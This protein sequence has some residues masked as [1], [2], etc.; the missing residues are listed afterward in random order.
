SNAN[1]ATASG[2]TRPTFKTNIIGS[3]PVLRFDGSDDGLIIG[4]TLSYGINP[5]FTVMALLKPSASGGVYCGNNTGAYMYLPNTTINYNDTVSP[6]ASDALTGALTDFK[7]VTVRRNV[8]NVIYRENKTA[9]GTHNIG[10]TG[11]SINRVGR[12]SGGAL[13]NGDYIE[14]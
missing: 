5:T 12:F 4:S 9:K 8:S 2:T 7:L 13:Y 6:D 1:D 3:T 14:F 11:Y 10:T